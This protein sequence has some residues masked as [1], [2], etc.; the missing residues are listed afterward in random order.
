MLNAGCNTTKCRKSK[1]VW[2]FSEGPVSL[3]KSQESAIFGFSWT[4][5]CIF[6]QNGGLVWVPRNCVAQI[7]LQH[8][9][10][11]ITAHL[12]SCRLNCLLP[13]RLGWHHSDSPVPACTAAAG[14]CCPSGCYGDGGVS[15]CTPPR[16]GTANLGITTNEYHPHVIVNV[17]FCYGKLGHVWSSWAGMG[18]SS[19]LGQCCPSL[20]MNVVVSRLHTVHVS[21]NWSLPVRSLI[22]L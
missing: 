21:V 4:Y 5:F 13:P 14:W 20:F 18:N 19:S 7:A 22:W 2:V 9:S 3:A 12:V 10:I 8:H 1:R 11:F 17:H 6:T 15:I 16:E